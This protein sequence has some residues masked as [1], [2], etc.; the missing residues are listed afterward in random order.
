MPTAPDPAAASRAGLAQGVS[1]L[2]SWAGAWRWRATAD[3]DASRTG[4]RIAVL[5]NC[6]AHGVLQ[7]LRLYL[8]DARVSLIDTAV[9][10]RSYGTLDRLDRHLAGFDHVF[11]QFFPDG[12]VAGGDANALVA[13]R[14]RIRLFPTIL[15]TAFHPDSVLVGDVAS[16]SQSGLINSPV[17]PYH[18]AIALCG[19]VEGLSVAATLG[20]FRDEVFSGL[21]YYD[22]WDESMAYMLR[23]SR[24]IGFGLENELARWSRRGC[25]M[26]VINHPKLFVLAEIARR[27]ATEAGLDPIEAKA[28]DYLA[29]D[30]VAD[31]IWPV[32]PAIAARYGL[33]GTDLFKRKSRGT[34]RPAVFGLADFVAASHATYAR[35]TAAQLASTRVEAWRADP[36]VRAVFLAAAR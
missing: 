21:G 5:G 3:P 9:L 31:A 15:F 30:L 4:P 6:Q 19:Y 27:L 17:G 32:Y 10:R 29:D 18:S 33:A 16:L 14:P 2:R 26:H 34:A 7:A 23:A 11:A 1:S 24:D 25:F 36:A 22:A 12:F 8:P 20:L 13:R 28:E 35:H